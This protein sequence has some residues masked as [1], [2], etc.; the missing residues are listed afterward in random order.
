MAKQFPF[1]KT[2]NGIK[3]FWG[4]I[5]VDI[6]LDWLDSLVSSIKIYETG[7]AFVISYAGTFVTHP[8]N[9][10]ILNHTIF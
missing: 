10:F 2:E 5:T 6:A 1:Y 4:I 8:N 7:F 3:K 9:D